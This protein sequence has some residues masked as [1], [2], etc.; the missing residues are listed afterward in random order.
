MCVRN[1]K[2][3]NKDLKIFFI[4]LAYK[5]SSRNK[6]VGNSRLKL[7]KAFTQRAVKTVKTGWFGP[8][9]R[10][11]PQPQRRRRPPAAAAPPP[12]V[13][14]RQRKRRLRRPPTV[15]PEPQPSRQ[16]R[17]RQRRRAAAAAASASAA[18]PE[19]EP[20]LRESAL[21]GFLHNYRIDGQN[22][23]D[24]HSFLENNREKIKDVLNKQ[25]KPIK[26]KLVLIC[27]FYRIKEGKKVWTTASFHSNRSYDVITDSTDMEAVFD[28]GMR[29]IT[30]EIDQFQ[31]K[32]SGWIFE[33][34]IHLDIHIDRYNP[35]AA[36]SG[37]ESDYQPKKIKIINVLNG[38][39]L[40]HDFQKREIMNE[41]L[42][43]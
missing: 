34:I 21:R 14:R 18:E 3:W 4:S 30:E 9:R 42:L 36:K 7:L 12:V 16:Q 43:N 13:Q 27:E 26:V 25:E 1:A 8:S 37:I 33:R 23:T 29:V 41:S 22:G 39:Q 11:Q 24:Y 40:E 38:Q 28:R 35:I 31:N 5:M 2:K 19:P 20:Q 15:A 17:R 10:P 6:I 32:S